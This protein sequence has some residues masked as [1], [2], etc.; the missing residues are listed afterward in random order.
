[1]E[2]HIVGFDHRVSF[3]LSLHYQTHV[4][5]NGLFIYLFFSVVVISKHLAHFRWI[6]FHAFSMIAYISKLS[7]TYFCVVHFSF[8]DSEIKNSIISFASEM[9][10]ENKQTYKKKIHRKPKR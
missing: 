10:D 8:F 7:S 3:V 9:M 6:F 2:S 5:L 1:M 4:T